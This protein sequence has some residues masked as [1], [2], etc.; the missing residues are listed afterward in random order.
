MYNPEIPMTETYNNMSWLQGYHVRKRYLRD[1][2]EAKILADIFF[3]NIHGV[4]WVGLMIPS[5]THLGGG[6]FKS[7]DTPNPPVIPGEDRCLEPL[8]AFSKKVWG[9]KYLLNRCLDV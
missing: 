1:P 2:R 7:L 5:D 8:K 6:V 4:L 9:F 3:W